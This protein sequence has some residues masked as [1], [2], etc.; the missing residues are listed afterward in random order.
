MRTYLTVKE[1]YENIFKNVFLLV[2]FKAD[3]EEEN[4]TPVPRENN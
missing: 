3:I 4:L 2:I 1:C